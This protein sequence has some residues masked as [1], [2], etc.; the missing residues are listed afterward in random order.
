MKQL[1]LC[2]Q[3]SSIKIAIQ[4]KRCWRYKTPNCKV[5]ESTSTEMR[6]N[7]STGMGDTSRSYRNFVKKNN[8]ILGNG[9]NLNFIARL[10]N[11]LFKPI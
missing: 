10:G 2:L 1:H 9:K 3:C 8:D 6:V 7:S 5:T 4:L 11:Y